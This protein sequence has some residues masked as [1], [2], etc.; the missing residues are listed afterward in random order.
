MTLRAAA[1][2]AVADQPGQERHG[3]AGDVDGGWNPR[4]QQ[5]GKIYAYT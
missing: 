3:G 5:I 1:G 4:D 2:R